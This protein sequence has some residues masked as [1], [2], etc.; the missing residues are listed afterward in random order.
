MNKASPGALPSVA[1]S[2]GA[3]NNCPPTLA[4]VLGEAVAALETA[5]GDQSPLVRRLRVL[6][7]RLQN[8]RFQLAVLGQFKRGKSSFINALLGASL[9]PTGVIPLTAVATF[10]AWGE[11]P[12]VAIHF[13][14]DVAGEVFPCETVEQVRDVLF[15]FVAEDANPKNE[16]DVERVELF[17]PAD[18]LVGGTTI[19]DTPGVGSTLQHNTQAALQVLPECDAAF[20]VVSAD[21]PITAIELG[22]L[23]GLRPKLRQVF[24]VLNKADYLGMTERLAAI[25]FL[26]KVLVQHSLIDADSHI[27]P[28]SARDA[29]AAKQ[30]GDRHALVASGLADLQDRLLALLARDKPR[31]LEDAVRSKAENILELAA[32]ELSLCERALNMPVEELGARSAAFEDALVA[33]EE[34][35]RVIRDLLVGERRRLREE[36][37]SRIGE[38]RKEIG[39]KLACIID[40][41][42][43][44]PDPGRWEEE[45]RQA[46]SDGL[47]K[48]FE[49]ARELLVGALSTAAANA[50][51]TCQGRVT[52]LADRVRAAAAQI[53]D[54]ALG[55][56]TAHERF[57][58]GQDPYWVTENKN[59][60]LIPD[61]SQLLD[62]LIPMALRRARL[63]A[64]MVRLADELIVR[65]A[66]NLRWAIV[67]GLDETFRRAADQF[68][69]RL[70]E[71]IAATRDVIRDAL[72]RRQGRSYAIQ[73]ELERI[74]R[75]RGEITLICDRLKLTESE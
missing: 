38:L 65:N 6:H 45:G 14:G 12:S 21:P 27:F 55:S 42:I 7:G 17:Y 44:T 24:L 2:Q 64:R 37:E 22:Y 41:A 26:R 69:Q 40:S 23:Q 5:L 43:A 74:S 28:V 70:G 13:Q 71:V 47:Q 66:E 58:L 50:L 10:I 52:A 63:S 11:S 57:E 33:I 60:T 32:A 4:H 8:E 29:L 48:E 19:I 73:P 18:I 49:A 68:E 20:F 36:L 35:R 1:L 59:T 51:C 30:L 62:R 31:L 61:V 53:F 75:A 67:L 9:L 46:I 54:V 25:D 3:S 16:L 39:T 56:D 72:A 15:R 34:Q